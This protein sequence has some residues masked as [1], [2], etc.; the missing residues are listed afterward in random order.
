[1][2]RKIPR[3]SEQWLYDPQVPTGEIRLDSA[4]WFEWLERATTIS[5]SYPNFEPSCGY[6]VGFLTVRKERKQRGYQYWSAYRRRNGRLQ[7]RY[8]GPSRQVRLARLEAIAE[9]YRQEGAEQRAAAEVA[10]KEEEAVQ[11]QEQAPMPQP[12]GEEGRALVLDVT[13]EEPRNMDNGVRSATSAA[14]SF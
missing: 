9:G 13:S 12:S 6:I 3:V 14:A 11:W 7:K 8:V 5:F 2:A 10:R 1:M 4:A